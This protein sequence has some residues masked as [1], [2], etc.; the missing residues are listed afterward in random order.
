MFPRRSKNQSDPRR[1]EQLAVRLEE[2]EAARRSGMRELQEAACGGA[3]LSE[4]RAAYKAVGASSQEPLPA[5]PALDHARPRELTRQLSTLRTRRQWYLM[6]APD[7][8]LAPAVVR[9]GSRAPKGP[10]VAGL[11][12]DFAQR[13]WGVDLYR[14]LELAFERLDRER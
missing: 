11:E 4:V 7:G 10:H 12:A 1:Y 5:S 14:A 9:P 2:A 3:P 13:R 8:A 6:N